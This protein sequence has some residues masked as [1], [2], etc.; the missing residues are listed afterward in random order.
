M[1]YTVWGRKPRQKGYAYERLVS[2]RRK[3]DAIKEAKKYAE[4]KFKAV[5]ITREKIIGM[6]TDNLEWYDG[7][8]KRIVKK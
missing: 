1:P 8:A 5:H 3:S 4:L 2:R 6:V 7:E